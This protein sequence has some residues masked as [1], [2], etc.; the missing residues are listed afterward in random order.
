MVWAAVSYW[1]LG[2]P[3]AYV[4]GFVLGGEEVGVWLGLVISLIC[5]S[6]LLMARFWRRAA[7][8]GVPA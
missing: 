8:L 7:Q 1:L 4:L 3:V 2:L 5:A 6:A